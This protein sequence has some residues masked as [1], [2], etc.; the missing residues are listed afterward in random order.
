MTFL[1]YYWQLVHTCIFI[2]IDIFHIQWVKTPLWI[3]RTQNKL[4]WTEL[5]CVTIDTVGLLLLQF[6]VSK[7][8]KTLFLLSI[9][10][11]S[12]GYRIPGDG[13][14]QRQYYKNYGQNECDLSTNLSSIVPDEATVM[15]FMTE[16]REPLLPPP[17]TDATAHSA[18]ICRSEVK[19]RW[20]WQ[21]PPV[22]L[23]GHELEALQSHHICHFSTQ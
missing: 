3:Y 11:R 13:D 18:N 16:C 15:V 5:N 10:S 19:L 14:I 23:A 6:S 22:G 2:Y 8:Y 4:N 12:V 9:A 7:T 17:A 20:P 1:A 21:C